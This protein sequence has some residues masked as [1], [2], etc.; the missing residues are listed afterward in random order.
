PSGYE[1][2]ELPLLHP[3][4]LYVRY[5]KL[6]VRRARGRPWR[7]PIV[8][9]SCPRSIVGA[10]AFHDRVREGNGWVHPAKTPG[11]SPLLVEP[12]GLLDAGS[13]DG[14]SGR[15]LWGR[16]AVRRWAGGA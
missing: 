4:S 1:P 3:A 11:P 8:P 13:P 9:R 2:D 7:R 15:G 6:R 14:P 16:S 5:S 10:G 12:R